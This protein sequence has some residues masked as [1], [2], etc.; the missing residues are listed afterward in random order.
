[1]NAQTTNSVYPEA[2]DAYAKLQLE[3]LLS[4]LAL[5]KR[6]PRELREMV[7]TYI[8]GN[9]YI[10]L[11]RR[12]WPS[13]YSRSDRTGDLTPDSAWLNPDFVGLDMAREGAEIYYQKNT[14]QLHD[15]QLK[16]LFQPQYDHGMDPTQYLRKLSV[17][18][19]Y[20]DITDDLQYGSENFFNVSRP[21][22]ERDPDK[23]ISPT[24]ELALYEER[25]EALYHILRLQRREQ[26]AIFITL[27]TVMTGS[28]VRFA[29]HRHLFNI[30][31]MVREPV[32]ELMHAGADVS[33]RQFNVRHDTF[34]DFVPTPRDPNHNI[35][36]LTKEEWEK[37]LRPRAEHQGL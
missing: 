7:Y 35:F 20:A 36:K 28:Q 8:Y 23:Y 15:S 3:P 6:L 27:D 18:V 17:A 29:N 9:Q 37:V 22:L 10:E 12:S 13:D 31:E 4:K 14:F 2:V 19:R 24:E 34:R 21:Y 32:Y 33:V 30:L 11:D 16:D 1:M 26:L 5:H 25:R